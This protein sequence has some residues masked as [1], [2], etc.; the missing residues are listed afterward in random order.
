M[1]DITI[2]TNFSRMK[3]LEG[4]AMTTKGG[5]VKQISS[6]ETITNRPLPALPGSARPLPALPGTAP[7][8]PA[9]VVPKPRKQLNGL[10]RNLLDLFIYGFG[11]VYLVVVFCQAFYF[12]L[13][14]AQLPDPAN[15]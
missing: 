5:E 13:L 10:L 15:L 3:K 7:A 14:P 9:I 12:I 8:K 4:G 6:G 11:F 2:S 1:H